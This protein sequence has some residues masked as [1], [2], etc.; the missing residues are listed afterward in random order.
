MRPKNLLIAIILFSAITACKKP[1]CDPGNM[2]GPMSLAGKWQLVQDSISNSWLK[3]SAVTTNYIGVA[4]DYFD[5]RSDGFCY[6]KEGDAYDTLAYK[7]VSQKS[8]IL[9]NFGLVV[10]GA[11]E[12]SVVTQTGTTANIT[13]QNI[14]SPAG[15]IFREVNLKR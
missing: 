4:G 13:T 6:T 9:Q 12:A 8:I 10:N 3:T 5:F 14:L 7:Q 1:G 11:T 15:T 2:N